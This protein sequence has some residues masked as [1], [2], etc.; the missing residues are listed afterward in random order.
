LINY[1]RKFNFPRKKIKLIEINIIETFVKITI[2][3][4]EIDSISVKFGLR[5]GEPISP[6]L[7]KL[8]LKKVIRKINIISQE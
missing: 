2:V 8:V 1:L 7:F 4:V 6:I 3:N 5:Q